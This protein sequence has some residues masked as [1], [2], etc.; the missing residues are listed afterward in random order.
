VA[1]I[2]DWEFAF[3][4][5]TFC[6]IGNMLRY[7]RPGNPRY[8]PHFSRGLA[9]GGWDAPGDWFLRARLAD[10]PALCELLARED[11]PD[12]I[13]TEIGDLIRETTSVSC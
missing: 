9:D 7:E 8:E 13:I 4:A 12:A 10:L 3:A 2:L 5:S 6:D 1:A 11:V